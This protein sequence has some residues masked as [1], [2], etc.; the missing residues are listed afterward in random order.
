[1]AQPSS[2]KE[3]SWVEVACLRCLAGNRPD[4]RCDVL[5][6]YLFAFAAPGPER[7]LIKIDQG[8]CV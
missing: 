4:G 6:Q 7:A 2:T 1:M 8:E 3:Y 5:S